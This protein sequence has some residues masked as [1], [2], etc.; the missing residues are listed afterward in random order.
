LLSSSRRGTRSSSQPSVCYPNLTTESLPLSMGQVRI[1][2]PDKEE[3]QGKD[4]G[5]HP[6]LLQ[7]ALC[8]S[9]KT[10]KWIMLIMKAHSSASTEK[11]T[12]RRGIPT[13]KSTIAE[14][15]RPCVQKAAAPQPIGLWAKIPCSYPY[16]N[17]KMPLLSS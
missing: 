11:N 3:N 6:A 2:Q 5:L 12:A 8:R 4:Q 13:H 17:L 14:A 15:G 1:S 9:G 16:K 7:L 10:R